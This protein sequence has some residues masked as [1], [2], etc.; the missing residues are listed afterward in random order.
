MSE[1]M[2]SPELFRPHVLFPDVPYD[3]LL[4]MAAY[5]D[6]DRAAIIYH[7]VYLTYREVVSMVN[8]IA[9]GM[10]NLGLRKGDKVCLLMTNRPEYTVS[11]I[12]AASIGVVV[13]PMNPAYK[14]REVG[15]QL[16]NSEASAIIIQSEL[17]PLLQLVLSQKSL[18]NL[19]Q[20][21]VTG[22]RVPESMPE[23]IPWAKLLR[24][25]F[26]RTASQS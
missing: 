24:R 26:V 9:N 23:A 15:Y 13:S 18:P 21:I 14:E 11:F 7:N 1:K 3:Q 6:P 8:S 2:V 19:K 22:D 25:I 5:R 16:E 10:Y 17:L 20:V 12:A 4:R